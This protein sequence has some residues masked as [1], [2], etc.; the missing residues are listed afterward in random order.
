MCA[1]DEVIKISP[2]YKHTCIFIYVEQMH[3]VISILVHEAPGE[4]K[5]PLDWMNNNRDHAKDHYNLSIPVTTTP[6]G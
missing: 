4:R 2:S 3:F 6:D 1:L 5:A